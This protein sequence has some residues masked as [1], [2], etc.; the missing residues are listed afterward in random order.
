MAALL[1]LAVTAFRFVY[2]FFLCPYDLAPDEAHY[3]DWSRHLDWSYYSKGP[4]VAWIIRAGC[5]L[6]ESLA[7][8]TNGTLMPAVRAPAVLCGA[9]LLAGLYVLTWQTYRS[10]K[11]ALQ[12][13]F[14][15]ILM[16]PVTLCSLIM[17]I[18]AP[19]LCCWAWALVF[20]RWA[21]VDGRRWAWPIAGVFISLGIL[22]KYTMALW[23]VSAGLFI[24]LTPSY[25]HL[26]WRSGFWIM[27]A[28]AAT[29]ALPILYWNSQNEWVTFRHVAVQAGVAEGKQSS[30]IR[31]LG[32]IEYVG[33]QLGVMMGIWFMLWLIAMI[34]YRPRQSTPAG[35][36]YLWW[37]S[38]PT[39]LVF[40]ASSLRASGQPNWPVAA[41]L[42]GSVLSIALIAEV[43]QSR[44]A[45]LRRL[46]NAS[47]AI[48][49]VLGALGTFVLHDMRMVTGIIA[50][51]VPEKPSETGTPFRRY[52]PAAR[53]KGARY[54]SGKL[55][56][57]R[58]RLV[59]SGESD[60]I[61]TGMRWDRPGLFGFYC[62]DHPQAYSFGLVLRTDRHSQYDHWRP[63]PIDDAQEFRDRTFIIVGLGDPRP[64]LKDAF[65]WFE[66]PIE[67]IY[68]EHDRILAR[69]QIYIC[70]G[71]RGF[72][73]SEPI[74]HGLG[75]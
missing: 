22:A 62:K 12:L 11:L 37:M 21:M 15:A 59:A 18:D 50:R 45:G 28:V 46:M 61:L 27:V 70:H 65:D 3:W 63:N 53:L 36:R 13:T 54:L 20:G 73:L 35:L 19:F 9:G 64:Q 40:G 31:W 6:F 33:S 43:W 67:V 71:F 4:L 1:I 47:I 24:L 8:S 30:G 38:A 68:R 74:G 41:Y 72:D 14:V 51:F 5:E 7:L 60:P 2:I 23:L 39:F 34:R 10:D 52:D 55:D 26:L 44:R 75:H 48:V 49:V 25:R 58:D 56:M 16:P 66:E 57:V 42:S 29:S 17:T 32:P 69:W